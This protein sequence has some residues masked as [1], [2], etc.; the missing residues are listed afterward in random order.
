EEMATNIGLHELVADLIK[1]FATN[2]RDEKILLASYAGQGLGEISR[3][4]GITGE[5]V[6]QTIC[7]ALARELGS[8]LKEA[9]MSAPWVLFGIKEKSVERARKTF[10]KPLIRNAGKLEIMGKEEG[11]TIRHVYRPGKLQ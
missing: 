8:A 6:R 2:P 7:K 1:E 10:A 4:I 3:Q 9:G 11:I 5:A